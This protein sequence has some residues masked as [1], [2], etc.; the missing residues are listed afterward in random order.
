MKKTISKRKKKQK[1]IAKIK[2]TK[3]YLWYSEISQAAIQKDISIIK[4][5]TIVDGVSLTPQTEEDYR[6]LIRLLNAKG[7]QFHT[8]QLPSQKLLYVVIK[9][10]PEPIDAAEV[11]EQLESRLFHPESVARMK[12][13]KDKRPLHMLLATFP[14]TKKQIYNTKDL[15]GLMVTVEE[16][17]NTAKV[18]QCHICRTRPKP[19]HS[20]SKM[21]KVCKRALNT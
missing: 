10:I 2:R 7:C 12:N 19:L 3:S 5:K 17:K 11:K 20:E 6:Q 14:K 9:G 16:Q 18:G 13:R 1:K 21:C 15:M 8:Y 4:A